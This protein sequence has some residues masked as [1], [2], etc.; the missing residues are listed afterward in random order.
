MSTIGVLL[1]RIVLQ[2]DVYGGKLTKGILMALA[3]L[4]TKLDWLLRAEYGDIRRETKT[5]N[6]FS[7][8]YYLTAEK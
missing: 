3:F 7:S 6:I 4:F 5:A 2:T 8:G 1:Q